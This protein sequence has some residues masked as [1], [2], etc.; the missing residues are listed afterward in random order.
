MYSRLANIVV[1]CPAFWKIPTG[2]TAEACPTVLGSRRRRYFPPN[3][4][5]LIKSQSAALIHELVHL[6]MPFDDSEWDEEYDIQDLVLLNA[7]SSVMNAQNY[8][9]YAASVQAGCDDFPLPPTVSR[10]DGL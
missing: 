1:L 3:Y 2:L 8:A 10:D 5:G 4:D 7:T 9:A 6:Y